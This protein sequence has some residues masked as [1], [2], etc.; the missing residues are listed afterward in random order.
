[1]ILKQ[2]HI[3]PNMLPEK[4]YWKCIPRWRNFH[5]LPLKERRNQQDLRVLAYTFT[6]T[7]SHH[8]VTLNAGMQA[9]VEL[10]FGVIAMDTQELDVGEMH[11]NNSLSIIKNIANEPEILII[12][13]TLYSAIGIL[14]SKKD[15]DKSRIY[16]EKAEAFYKNVKSNNLQIMDC[17]SCF[18]NMESDDEPSAELTFE[19]K[20]TLALYYLAQI[21][22]ELGDS[23]KSS[24]YC[25]VTLQRQLEF[26]DYEPIDWALNAA[27][28]SQFFI[29]KKGFKQAR[30]LLAASSYVLDKYESELNAV[31]ATLRNEEH[32]AKMETFK[33]RASD[34]ARCWAKYGLVL[35]EASKDRLLNDTESTCSLQTDL[36]KMKLEAHSTISSKDLQNL[37]F[38]SLEVSKYER[39]I[40]DQ[41][42]LTL[43]DA[44]KIIPNIQKW[45]N[46]ALLYCT[47]EQC[48]S[49]Y[50]KISL[51]KADMYDGLIFFDGNPDNKCK[52]Y[53]KQADI[54]EP[55]VRA[56]NPVYYMQYCRQIWYKLGTVYTEMLRIKM[57][58]LKDEN[59]R[60]SD[61]VV[62]KINSL[63]DK[64]ISSFQLYIDSFKPSATDGVLDRVPEESEITFLR[65]HFH[66]GVLSNKFITLDKAKQLENC[67]KSLNYYKTVVDYADRHPE[68]KSSIAPELGMMKE[69]LTLLPLQI[70]MLK[71]EI[72]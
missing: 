15:P 16:L 43:S 13:I 55:V 4:S 53:K 35:L 72:D 47:L 14:L 68:C 65:A 20:F 71:H 22:H 28:L 42:L 5:H 24:I 66:T 44:A 56:V 69:M 2:T 6:D 52:L 39:E 41:F 36:T 48:A 3:V 54:L 58:K 26:N 49:E 60:P 27:T 29:E 62:S 40:T 17:E 64:G 63:I 70:L 38:P 23:L 21:Y 31:P 7:L 8:N 19:K 46:K 18:R 25:H 57:D 61:A 33:H 30:H 45:L 51:D 10:D 9:L 34:I 59:A 1:M 67:E 50:M 37:C 12:T 11:F 32:D